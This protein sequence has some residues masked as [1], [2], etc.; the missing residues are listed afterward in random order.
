MHRH[1]RRDHAGIGGDGTGQV[2]RVVHL[3]VG[4][5]VDV[6]VEHRNGVRQ[7]PGAGLRCA[8]LLHLVTVHR[9]AV[10]FADD[11]DA[12][13]ASVTEHR[14]AGI[15]PRE[16]TAQELIVV[17]GGAQC[18]DV[19]AQFADLRGR[20]VDEAQSVAGQPHGTALEQRVAVALGDRGRHRRIGEVE[21]VVPDQHMDAC[22]VAAAHLHAV[23]RGERLL[24]GQVARHRAHTCVATGQLGDGV[25][26]ADAILAHRPDG[27]AH[28]QQLC[29]DRFDLV[30][31]EHV[32]R[33]QRPLAIDDAAIDLVE[34][35]ADACDQLAAPDECEHAGH[36]VQGM[37]HLCH[38][39]RRF[40]ERG[41]S[42]SS[43]EQSDEV[44]RQ[45]NG[46]AAG[47]GDDRDDATHMTNRLLTPVVRI[48]SARDQ[49]SGK[50]GEATKPKP[51]RQPPKQK[52]SAEATQHHRSKLIGHSV[53]LL[54]R[55]GFHHH[56]DQRFGSTGAHQDATITSE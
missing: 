56:A 29:V 50:L 23:D 42:D 3:D 2:Q 51:R 17:H 38:Q 22:A 34:A 4:M 55:G 21:A 35:G 32:A 47:S 7:L 14:D 10:G 33:F 28:G 5:V 20:L 24:N 46:P 16:G 1:H 12:G 49:V 8:R 53:R 45:W 15:G 31:G 41:C 13:P 44:A 11:A 48:R 37:I 26:R 52:E 43:I 9:V 39:H 27:V 40:G 36:P 18:L 19:V 30:G 6:A 25:R 54:L